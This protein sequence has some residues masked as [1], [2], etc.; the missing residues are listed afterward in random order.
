[1]RLV[2]LDNSYRRESEIRYNCACEQRFATLKVRR[3][4]IST[5]I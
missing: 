5:V 3:N 2:K 1:M 4:V